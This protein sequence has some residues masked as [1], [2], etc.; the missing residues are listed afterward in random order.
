MR[1][2]RGV[3]GCVLGVTAVLWAAAPWTAAAATNYWVVGSADW[4]TTKTNWHSSSSYS[5]GAGNGG[6]TRTYSD[7]DSVYF[8][9][10]DPD[11]RF[12]NAI[13]IVGDV[14][15]AFLQVQNGY[16]CGVKLSG[17][18]ITGALNMRVDIQNT[19]QFLRAF[20]FNGTITLN[21]SPGNNSA[22]FH[23]IPTA[24]ATLTQG[25]A[26][27]ASAGGRL[28]GNTNAN[29]SGCAFTVA[30]NGTL[31]IP[32]TG[33]VKSNFTGLVVQ[34]TGNAKFVLAYD[35]QDSGRGCFNGRFTGSSHFL[36]MSEPTQQ[37]NRKNYITGPGNWTIAGLIFN[38]P[39]FKCD[40]RASNICGGSLDLQS[41][42]MILAAGTT[43]TVS[44][45]TITGVVR[46]AVGTYGSTASGANFPDDVRFEGLGVVELAAGIVPEVSIAANDADAAEATPATAPGQ[47]TVTRDTTSGELV[48]NY[49]VTGTAAAGDYVETLS[50]SVTIPNGQASAAIDITPVDDALGEYPETVTLTLSPNAFYTIGTAAASVTIADNDAFLATVTIAASD[51]WAGEAGPNPGQFTVTR[52]GTVGDLMVNYALTGT[53]AAGDYSEMLGGSIVIADGQASATLD[54]TPVDDGT[55]ESGETVILTLATHATY[56]VGAPSSATVTIGDNDGPSATRYW[57][58]GDGIWDATSINWSTTAGGAQSVSF[59]NGDSVRMSGLDPDNRKLCA[60]NIVSD[61]SPAGLQVEA[62]FGAGASLGGADIVGALNM[63]VGNQNSLQFV[64]PFSFVGTVT[65][66]T[67]ATDLSH[68]YFR[69]TAPASLTQAVRVPAGKT[70]AIYGNSHANWSQCAFTL[71]PGAWLQIPA[72]GGVTSNFTGLVVTLAGDASARIEYYY[73]DSGRACFN[74]RFD[75]PSYFLTLS[76]PPQEN[77]R[78]NYITGPGNWTIAGLIFNYPGFKCDIRASNICGKSLDLQNGIMMLAVGTTQQVWSLTIAGVAKMTPGTY[79][80][81]ASGATYPDDLHFAGLGVVRR[82]APR[83]TSFTLR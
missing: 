43:Q 9:G 81:S 41:G 50:G 59:R 73:Q 39:G 67:H 66:G 57:A 46:T 16:G 28:Y 4:D 14:A 30:S 13:N 6:G 5:G 80:S 51:A 77:N 58:V 63:Q 49:T 61:V 18:D 68:F 70:G 52:D 38:Y 48:V 47:F 17:A 54:V 36:T 45:L 53:A 29:W 32:T 42:T 27:P 23:F 20:S 7:G 64:R 37:S 83:G 79:G 75:G 71:E 72:T 56:L 25:C 22:N 44:A 69:P 65:V 34:L 12:V 24:P 60:I 55:V 40:I 82:L 11:N 19:L 35:Y 3:A 1:P 2:A 78:L 15:P 74:G 21:G 26:L 62:G 8:S 10:S 76:E 33:G 31:E